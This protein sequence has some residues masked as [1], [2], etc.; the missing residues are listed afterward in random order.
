MPVRS[1]ESALMS[2]PQCDLQEYEKFM[3]SLYVRKIV[4]P[5]GAAL[6]SRV[7][8]RNYAD[9]MISGDIT[10]NDSNGTYRLTGFNLLEGNA[11]RKRAGF[12]HEETIWVTVHDVVDIKSSPKEDISFEQIEDWENYRKSLDT[13]SYSRLL[14]TISMTEEDV[15]KEIEGDR[16]LVTGKYIVKPSPVGGVGVF[17]DRRYESGEIVGKTLIDGV[18]TELGRYVNHSEYPNTA[19]YDDQLVVI[20]ALDK[21]QEF[22]TNYYNSPRLRG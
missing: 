4:I 8:K 16:V 7:Y 22:T 12:A 14:E 19:F 10:I 20:R 15:Q 2:L 18:K 13:E 17:S 6:T 21:D 9:I 1:L 11:G 5:K 3:G